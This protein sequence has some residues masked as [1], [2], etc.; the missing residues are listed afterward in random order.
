MCDTLA[1]DWLSGRVCAVGVTGQ[2]YPAV[3]ES[4]SLLAWVKHKAYLSSRNNDSQ[5]SPRTW[6]ECATPALVCF[7]LVPE[8]FS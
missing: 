6:E 3:G 4:K 2:R 5:H 8:S 7:K 1:L